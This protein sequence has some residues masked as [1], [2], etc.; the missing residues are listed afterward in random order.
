MRRLRLAAAAAVAVTL[1]VA[2][3]AA[4]VRADAGAGDCESRVTVLANAVGVDPSTLI[5]YLCENANFG[6]KQTQ[7]K[8]TFPELPAPGR[9]NL[10]VVTKRI[11]KEVVITNPDGQTLKFGSLT[12]TLNQ[13]GIGYRLVTAFKLASSEGPLDCYTRGDPWRIMWPPWFGRSGPFTYPLSASFI[14]ELADGGYLDTA[15]LDLSDVP[16]GNALGFGAWPAQPTFDYLWAG[17][18]GEFRGVH[19]PGDLYV[20]LILT[21]NAGDE[22]WR[23]S[24]WSYAFDVNGEILND[25]FDWP[26]PLNGPDNGGPLICGGDENPCK[27]ETQLYN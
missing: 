7:Q 25:C 15:R 20:T 24:G 16:D 19:V 12:V 4:P 2:S 8:P 13:G 9:G 1:L 27:V 23:V 10:H 11:T 14:R 21:A 18:P 22:K 17:L 26:R 3:P 6:G 5:E